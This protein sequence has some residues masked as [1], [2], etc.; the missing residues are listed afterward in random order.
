MVTIS[1][2]KEDEDVLVNGTSYHGYEIQCSLNEIVSVF[3]KQHYTSPK[4]EKAQNEWL[5]ETSEGNIVT[6][7]DWKQHR[8]FGDDEVIS[9]HIGSHGRQV[10]RLAEEL[11]INELNI[12]K[13]LNN[14]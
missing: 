2:I 12:Y 11:I 5:L 10:S 8:N 4:F 3:G 14:G 7:Y 9:W 13:L 1:R 6:I